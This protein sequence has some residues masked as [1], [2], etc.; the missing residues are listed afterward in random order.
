MN[1][2][3][4]EITFHHGKPVAAYYYLPRRAGQKVAKTC[5]AEHGLL[6]DHSDDG[7]AV[8]IEITAPAE[9]TVA[10]INHVLRSLGHTPVIEEELA[11]LHAD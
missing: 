11:P 9:A 6:I 3:Y 2:A 1:E 4:L 10:A 8:G 5:R 7:K